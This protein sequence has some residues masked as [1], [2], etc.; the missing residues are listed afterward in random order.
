MA[1]AFTV[2]GCDV[3]EGFLQEYI[4]K[5]PWLHLV[6]GNMG[7]ALEPSLINSTTTNTKPVVS[8]KRTP[9]GQYL[10][11]EAN[12]DIEA[13][14]PNRA[15]V[16]IVLD[17]F[18]LEQNEV[19]WTDGRFLTKPCEH[20]GESME[21]DLFCGLCRVTLGLAGLHPNE[22]EMRVGWNT[23]PP[24]DTLLLAR[25]RVLV[26]DQIHEAVL[27]RMDPGA[28]VRYQRKNGREDHS[29]LEVL[30][31]WTGEGRPQVGTFQEVYD[32][33]RDKDSAQYI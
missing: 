5:A 31:R 12:H 23:F 11:V 20:I 30:V 10:V 22:G 7:V 2:R 8:I 13:A 25:G 28:I 26:H 15:V 6:V 3:R 27:I 21:N 33:M 24:E 18:E 19:T 16:F 9:S 32:P 17:P 29:P 1:M 14:N 4:E